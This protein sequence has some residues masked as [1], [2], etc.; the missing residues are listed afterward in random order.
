MNRIIYLFILAA[1][2]TSALRKAK[3]YGVLAF[4][5]A[6]GLKKRDITLEDLRLSS[7]RNLQFLSDI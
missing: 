4:L 6:T 7:K 3:L 2:N 1:F 5:S